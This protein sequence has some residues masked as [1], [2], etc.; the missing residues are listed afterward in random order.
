MPE[1][2]IEYKLSLERKR[3]GENDNKIIIVAGNNNPPA[4]TQ[5]QV[6]TD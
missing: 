5:A 4:V 3:Q 6:V 2:H 1:T